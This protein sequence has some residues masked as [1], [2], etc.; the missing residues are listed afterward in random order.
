MAKGKRC[1]DVYHKHQ[2]NEARLV[3]RLDR[4]SRLERANRAIQS[5]DRTALSQYR[6]DRDGTKVWSF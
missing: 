6:L 2:N 1:G 5:T 4:K 3:D